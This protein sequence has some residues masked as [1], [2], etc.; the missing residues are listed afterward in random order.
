MMCGHQELYTSLLLCTIIVLLHLSSALLSLDR[1]KDLPEDGHVWPSVGMRGHQGTQRVTRTV[2]LAAILS[3][4][5][6]LS[7]TLRPATQSIIMTSA[8]SSALI[9]P[10]WM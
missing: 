3:A 8:N 2:S 6:L 9:T 5:A 7:G 4:M 1:C 10:C